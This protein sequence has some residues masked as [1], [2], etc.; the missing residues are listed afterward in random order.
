MSNLQS[1]N[2][3]ITHLKRALKDL[4]KKISVKLQEHEWLMILLHILLGIALALFG[5]W[6]GYRYKE[7]GDAFK[8]VGLAFSMK[9]A[10][11]FY[12]N[13]H[14]RKKNIELLNSAHKK[15]LAEF[16]NEIS[17]QL[18]DF[19]LALCEQIVRSVEQNLGESE[20]IRK[21]GI[22]RIFKG[23]DLEKM[24][25]DC[26]NTTIILQRLYFSQK[27]FKI[28]NEQLWDLIVH[29]NCTVKILLLSP[30]ERG[31][32]TKRRRSNAIYKTLLGH[33]VEQLVDAI[34]LQLE[35]LE[36]F[37]LRLP[38]N[39][40]ENLQVQVHA[41]YAIGPVTAFNNTIMAGLYMNE[42]MS[43]EGF[44]L[45][46]VGI[47]TYAYQ[48]WLSTFN[49]QWL[50]AVPYVLHTA[51]ISPDPPVAPAICMEAGNTKQN[52]KI[53][54]RLFLADCINKAV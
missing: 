29:K 9:A 41:D 19:S 31:F 15:A 5:A 35:T 28:I 51:P 34:K 27:E 37:K 16:K 40:I 11:T 32:I 4:W 23:L 53:G 17:M 20:E 14:N 12:K 2:T 24:L 7:W 30:T 21:A 8:I 38:K 25:K 1:N 46:I 39:K 48:L 10:S 26:T 50:H 52:S 45:E 49:I 3:F 44:Q 36:A 42:E 33:G 54:Q 22:K 6:L 43:E 47:D 18:K 13:A